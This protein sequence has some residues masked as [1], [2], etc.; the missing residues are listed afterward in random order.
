MHT[1]W[2]DSGTP[3][4]FGT[5][6]QLTVS[7]ITH[8]TLR[9]DPSRLLAFVYYDFLEP[10]DVSLIFPF[11]SLQKGGIHLRQLHIPHLQ[12]GIVLC[13]ALFLCL[14]LFSHP[15]IEQKQL[16][17]RLTY[18]FLLLGSLLVAFLDFPL[19]ESSSVIC[20][21]L[22]FPGYPG[23][24]LALE[25]EARLEKD[26]CIR[27]ILPVLFICSIFIGAMLIFAN[28]NCMLLNDAPEKYLR[29]MDLFR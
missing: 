10:P 16:S 2:Q 21:T 6:Y 9:A 23:L 7:D 29:I 24:L 13:P 19:E 28:E 25:Y 11:I 5:G 1:T 14:F 12:H 15:S 18:L 4:E 22:R 3:T 26:R 8:N 20:A 17:K 27:N